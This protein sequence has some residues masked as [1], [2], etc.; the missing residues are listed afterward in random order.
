MSTL[1][2][3]PE[4][5]TGPGR[6]RLDRPPVPRCFETRKDLV[7]TGYLLRLFDRAEPTLYLWRRERGLPYI[8]IPGD[9][10][11]VIRYDLRKV[12]AWA[13][14]NRIRLR[15]IPEPAAPVEAG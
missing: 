7:T 13:K 4:L 9:D 15:A 1:M 3:Q 8:V 12:I 6:P 2:E 11:P 5:R 14:K 10:R